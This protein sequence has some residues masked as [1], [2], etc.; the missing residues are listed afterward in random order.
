MSGSESKGGEATMVSIPLSSDDESTSGKLF[1][2]YFS[3]S[4]QLW[5]MGNIA[6]VFI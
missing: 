4:V 3:D 6:L 1:S 5:P 2:E